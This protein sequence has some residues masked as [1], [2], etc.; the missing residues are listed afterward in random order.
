MTTGS[1]ITLICVIA[2]LYGSTAF[3]VYKSL[4]IKHDD[5]EEN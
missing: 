3:A 2:G 5:S 4:T 1:M